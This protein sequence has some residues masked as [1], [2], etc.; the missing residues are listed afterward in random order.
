VNAFESEHL[1]QTHNTL[2]DFT[3]FYQ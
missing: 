2:N 3:V 1:A